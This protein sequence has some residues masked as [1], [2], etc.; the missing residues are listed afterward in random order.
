MAGKDIEVE[1]FNLPKLQ[2]QWRAI[3]ALMQGKQFSKTLFSGAQVLERAVK[4]NIRSQQLIDTGYYRT[5]VASEVVSNTEAIVGTGVIYGPIHEFGGT[6]HPRTAK[7]LHFKIGEGDDA[8]WVRTKSVTI[9]A[10]PHWRPAFDEKKQE[11]ANVIGNTLTM[12][13]R[14]VVI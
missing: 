6:I 1:V 12:L 2:G 8:V 10:R 14:R 4:Q 11:A 5:S 9:P 13:I 7:Y 3:S